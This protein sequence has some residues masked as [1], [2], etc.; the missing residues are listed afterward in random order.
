VGVEH[1]GDP[2]I[3]VADLAA[4]RIGQRLRIDAV[5]AGDEAIAGEL[6][7]DLIDPAAELDRIVGAASPAVARVVAAPGG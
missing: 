1:E 4:T 5:E 2:R 7:P 6:R 3:L